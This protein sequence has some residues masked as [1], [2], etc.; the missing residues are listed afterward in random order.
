M[1]WLAVLLCCLS[2]M[3]AC[4]LPACAEEDI[5]ALRRIAEAEAEAEA[6]GD[7]T[8]GAPEEMT[9]RARGLSLQAL[10]PEISVTGDI[11]AQYRDQGDITERA[12]MKARCLGLHLESYLDP[13][14]RFKAAVEFSEEEI[15]LGEVYFT[16]F[17]IA[18]GLNFTLGKF[19]QPFGVVNRW[20]KHGLDQLDFPLPLL[21]IFGEEG[22]NQTGGSLDWTMPPLGNTSQALTFQVTEGK[23]ERVFG[24]NTKSTPSM[25]AR[26]RNYRDISK[27]TYLELGLTG[28]L[29]WN[30]EWNLAGDLTEH[31][32]L[33]A[34][35]LGADLTLLWE[36]TDRMRYRNLLWRTEAYLLQK[37]ILAP[38]ASGRDTV[39]A[40]GAYTYIQS[41]VSRTCE[42]GIR[43]DYYRPDSKAYAEIGQ[44]SPLAVVDDDAY[45]WQVGPYITWYQSP[46]V[47]FRL[48]YNHEDGR[49]MEPPVDR[50][51]LQCIFAAGPHKH[52]RY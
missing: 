19:R 50:L 5:E 7:A 36:P 52:E 44:L 27:D 40:W 48:E 32:S 9:F 12:K 35:V 34:S 8:A 10:N 3:L 16:R 17:G 28:L 14:S 51:M 2:L 25:L 49:S 31:E 26:Y 20:H 47:R 37:D 18:E 46:W 13:Y 4:A 11:I 45:R 1:K 33:P 24:G 39:D 43:V 42:I 6:S 22:L 21:M 38:D 30:D 23:N 41:K 29:G 15:G